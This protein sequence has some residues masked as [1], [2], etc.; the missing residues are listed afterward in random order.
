MF[1]LNLK[2]AWRNLWRNKSYTLINVLG[3]SVGMAACMLIFLFVYYQLSFDAG[4]PQKNRI[5]RFVTT[6]KYPA[7]D[8]FSKGIP[9]P[10]ASAVKNELTGIEK[11]AVI[12]KKGGIIHVR[13]ASGKDVIKRQDEFY[14]AEPDFFDVFNWD[15][16]SGNARQA[17]SAPN[18]V[19]LSAST[20]I[21]YF[22]SVEQA[23]GKTMQ[24]GNKLKLTVTGIFKDSPDNSSFPLK[25]VVSYSTFNSKKY[26]NWD[27]VNSSMEFYVLLKQGLTARDMD[28]QIATFNKKY[29]ERTKI[30]GQ[31]RNKLQALE[32]VHF[33][34]RYGS[35]ADSTVSR[36]EVYGLI[37][38]GVFLL[39]TA[40]INF[41]NLATAQATNRSKEVGVRKVMGGSR[42]QL[43]IQFLTETFV[44]TLISM[45]AASILTELT[46]PAMSALLHI[47][48]GFFTEPVVYLFMIALLLVVSVL[49]GA[50]PALIIS[51]Y[52]PALAI[53]NRVMINAGALGLR[54]IL[55]VTQFSITVVLLISSLFI[56][57]Q[58]AYLRD[59]PLGFNPDAIAM[60]GLPGDSLSQARYDTF[61][62][63]AMQIP[64]V[65]Q[66]SFC[67]TPPLSDDITTS[68]F[69]FKGIP[70]KDFELRQMKAD[71]HYFGL[72]DLQLVA[73]KQFKKGDEQNFA[74]VNETFLRKMG[75]SDPQSVVG[76]L[77]T[78]NGHDMVITGV[79]KDYNDLSLKAHISP[80]V[81]FPQKAEYYAIAVK[82]SGTSIMPATQQLE[83]LWNTTF[84]ESVYQ[85]SFLKEELNSYY[86]SERVMGILFNIAEG[87]IV[88]ISLIGLFGL[89]SFVAAQRSREVAIRKVLGA[90]SVQLVR[91]LNGSFL[92]M[93]MIANLLAWPLAYL[94]ISKWLDTFAYRIELSVWPFVYAFIISMGITIIT[95]SIK[96]YRTA[97]ANMIDALKYE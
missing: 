59:Q 31:Q 65:K 7:Y 15:W 49:A 40:C 74:V 63:R 69:S 24:I 22:G 53:K 66:I 80:V 71:E 35:F 78:T 55:V 83:H 70:N 60:V 44:I 37:V 11:S 72:F 85:S 34:Q 75:I 9:L 21:R 54:R 29:Y 13:D 88:F 45:L 4:H 36:K 17:L 57:K 16:L 23:I 84:P 43:V 2:I 33:D 86:E 41:I 30:L 94:F 87:V 46:L 62:E 39:L 27:G 90:S 50:Y 58:M 42:K 97:T 51:G 47:S 91:L 20:A 89:I 67:Q 61:K 77:L 8:D 5:F 1:K 81:I 68:D 26:I 48:L 25:I 14:Y 92:N 18:T 52:S 76:Q 73:G 28:Q 38:I 32:D 64:G 96:S 79:V 19:A 10:L 82:F 56:M 3:L 93:V 95:V 6:W 12:I